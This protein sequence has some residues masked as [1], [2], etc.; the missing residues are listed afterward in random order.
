MS[1]Q[2]LAAVPTTSTASSP[3]WRKQAKVA[4]HHVVSNKTGAIGLAFFLIFVTIILASPLL[5]LPDAQA[6]NLIDRLKAPGHV[7]ADGTTHWLGTDQLGRDVLSRMLLGGCVSLLV[8]GLTVLISGSIGTAVG[9]LAGFRGGWIDS[10]VMRLVDFQMALPSLLLA[11]FLLYI[12]GSSVFNLVLLLSIMSWY[13]YTRVVRSEVLRLKSAVYVDAARSIGATDS[14]LMFLHILPQV[15]PILLV[16]AV[17]DFGVVM[18]TES[19]ISFLGLGI[20]P[21]DTSWGRMISEG[22]TFITTGAWW[23]F[24]APGAGIFLTVLSLRLSSGWLTKVLGV[25]AKVG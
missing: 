10:T 5:P 2:T 11:I 16:I 4:Q 23:V 13:S 19:S 6:P 18:L 25:N 22:Q 17:F 8:A 15:M 9:L 12:I 7:S 21:P 20:Q 3:A 24:A 14:R 1:T